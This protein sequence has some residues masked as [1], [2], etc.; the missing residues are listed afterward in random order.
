[1]DYIPRNDGSLLQWAINLITCARTNCVRW[2]ITESVEGMSALCDSF[3]DAIAAASSPNRGKVDV[4][5]KN[6][7]HRALV[8]ACRTFVQGFLARNPYVTGDDRL[9]MGL[10]IRDDVPTAIADPVGLPAAE[11][12]YPGFAQLQLKLKHAEGTPFDKKSDYGIKVCYGVFPATD[13]PPADVN[14][15][16][17]S[18]FSRKK[19]VLFKFDQLDSGKRAW[20]CL[21][22][23]NSKGKSGPLSPMFSAIIP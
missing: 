15:L 12:T 3:S 4:A 6:E 13:P 18:R 23:E 5:R 16:S 7:A 8:K 10:N 14:G 17:K 20:F 19:I 22:Y 2:K 11:I 21:A 9:M 1:M